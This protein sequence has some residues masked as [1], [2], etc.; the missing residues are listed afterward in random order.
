[1]MWTH[2]E[3]LQY[4]A[5]RKE[6]GIYTGQRRGV[7]SWLAF[8]GDNG[9]F[10]NKGYTAIKSPSI[11]ALRPAMRDLLD[12]WRETDAAKRDKAK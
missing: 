8:G 9:Q 7:M 5:S 12:F 10:I 3:V 4:W 6:R 11:F 1:M 2:S